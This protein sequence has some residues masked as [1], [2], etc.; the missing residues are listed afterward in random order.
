VPP[1]PAPVQQ[2]APAGMRRPPAQ[3]PVQPV[4]QQVPMAYPAPRRAWYEE[5]A[6]LATVIV[7]ILVII[8]FLVLLVVAL[9]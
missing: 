9:L 5:P 2:Q 1:R 4:V 3:Q 7:L 6:K 8:L